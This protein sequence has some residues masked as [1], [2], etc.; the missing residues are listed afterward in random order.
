MVSLVLREQNES[1]QAKSDF[2]WSFKQTH[3]HAKQSSGSQSSALP[4]L[5]QQFAVAL[6][7]LLI[8]RIK[9]QN[10]QADN[11]ESHWGGRNQHLQGY[12]YF[13][14]LRAASTDVACKTTDR[15]NWIM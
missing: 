11:D 4:L 7:P 10:D 6:P 9:V 8:D 1:F 2:S 13:L 5:L 12:M 15:R 3:T 14:W